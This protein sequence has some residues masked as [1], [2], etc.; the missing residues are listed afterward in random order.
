MSQAQEPKWKIT[1][2]KFLVISE[3]T[4]GD[5][6]KYLKE[7]EEGYKRSNDKALFHGD[8]YEDCE[9]QIEFLNKQIK[10]ASDRK[11]QLLEE[12][13]K[14]DEDLQALHTLRETPLRL[15]KSSDTKFAMFLR[16]TKIYSEK[17]KEFRQE[18]RR[19]NLQ[20]PHR[21]PGT[22]IGNFLKT[23]ET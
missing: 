13:K 7:A 10:S 15:M 5:L 6:Y 8:R 17:I 19:R 22:L 2:G 16:N 14:I 3:M 12:L 20:P 21:E 18:M 1:P 4:D 23:I 9:N 11:T